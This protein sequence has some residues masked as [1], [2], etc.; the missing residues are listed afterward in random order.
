MEAPTHFVGRH[1]LAYLLLCLPLSLFGQSEK[2][3]AKIDS[4]LQAVQN[5]ADNDSLLVETYL[6][7]ADVYARESLYGEA[8]EYYDK[9]IPITEKANNI[10]RLLYAM[11]YKAYCLSKRGENKVAL[12]LMIEGMGIADSLGR[13]DIKA[14]YLYAIGDYFRLQRRTEMALDYLNRAEVLYK[15]LGDEKALCGK[16]PYTKAITYKVSGNDEQVRMAA[17]ILKQMLDGEC[18]QSMSKSQ[19]ARTRGNLGAIYIDLK[20]YGTAEKYLLEALELKKQSNRHHSIAYTLNELASLNFHQEKYELA[21]QWAKEALSY[22]QKSEDIQLSSDITENIALSS[23]YIG[24]TEDAINYIGISRTLED[25]IAKIEYLA[26]IAELELRYESSQKDQE[27]AQ[28]ELQLAQFRNGLLIAFLLLLLSIGLFIWY[29]NRLKRK[30]MEAEGRAKLELMRNR[31]FTN[32]SHELRTPL[33]LIIDPIQQLKGLV[34]SPHQLNLVRTVGQQAQRMLHLI[35]QMLDLNK[36]E[37]GK[38]Q[39]EA[40]PSQLYNSLAAI[41]DSFQMQAKLKSIQLRFQSDETD[42]EVYSDPD[43]LE[44]ILYNLL[45]NALKFTPEG[46]EVS[47]L[48]S[49]ETTH[50]L[51]TVKDNGPGISHAQQPYIFDRFYQVDD[52]NTRQHDGT[53]IGLSLAKELVELHQG[54][55]DVKSHPGEGT[56]MLLRL[57]LGK[58]H[59]TSEQIASAKVLPMAHKVV[60]RLGDTQLPPPA[61]APS[62]PTSSDQPILLLVE[63]NQELRQYLLQQLQVDYKILQATNGQEGVELALQEIPDII[64][65]DIMMPQMDGNELCQT[66]KSDERTAHIPIILLTAKSS[67]E[68]R[69]TGLKNKADDYLSKPFDSVELRTRAGNLVEQRLQLRQKFAKSRKIS[70]SE[71]TVNSLDEA[72]LQRALEAIEA[73]MEDEQFGVEQLSMAVGMS[74]SQLHRKLKALTGQS[75]SA[76]LR[77]IRLRRAYQLLEQAAGNASEIAFQVGFGNP[78][79]F[80]KCFKEEFSI[81]PGQ[82][83]K[84]QKAIKSD[85]EA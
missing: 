30:E 25:S 32:I 33:S 19:L 6:D 45:S 41:V 11:D 55:I 40:Q 17:V 70:P 13:D 85:G 39:L 16:I 53:G 66:L 65:S 78:N 69:I 58:D 31:Y 18:S 67:R 74:R 42:L 26:T 50:A 80:F 51:I 56:S 77:S 62:T 35:N 8:I 63:D 46:G 84:G 22:A 82:V 4:L 44:K 34:N 57:P 36:L 71:I 38:M 76:F 47:V 64:I 75:T 21:N 23:I 20:E 49:R 28:Q 60:S 52:S 59:L 9:V 61:A 48:L 10:D 79:Y 1:L 27:I 83:L 24:A 5:I 73:K 54:S 15:K 7:L 43:K 37:A 68:D 3:N 81:T 29:R 14:D 72:F 2:S 12:D